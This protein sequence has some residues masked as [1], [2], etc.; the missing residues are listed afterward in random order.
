MQALG[1]LTQPKMKSPIKKRLLIITRNFPPLVGGM[2]RLNYHI[3]LELT[4][5]FD[6]AI[7][8]PKGCEKYLSPQTKFTLFP[9]KPLGLF[10]LK[11]FTSA[12]RLAIKEKPDLIIAGS[13]VTAII[14]LIAARSLGAKAMIFIHGLDILFPNP[15]YQLL[16]L[17]AIRSCD[18]IWV[19]SE[20]TSTLA[21]QKGIAPKKINILH[22]GVTLP[23]DNK[24]FSSQVKFKEKYGISANRKILLSVG[25]LTHRKGLAE[26][27]QYCL[28]KIV[29]KHPD[30]LLLIVGNNAKDALNK[31]AN[32]LEKIEQATHTANVK[33]HVLTLGQLSEDDLSQAYI[34]SE[35]LVFPVLNLPGDVEGFGMVAIEAAAHGLPTVAFAVGGVTDAVG[36]GISGW[37]VEQNN[38]EEFTQTVLNYLSNLHG[39]KSQIVTK[40]TCRQHATKFSWD[41]FGYQLTNTCKDILHS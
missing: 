18:G 37:L 28:A 32:I 30:I 27:I 41:R 5:E 25:R 20:H 16:F 2:E 9:H 22:P 36:H 21:K 40:Q 12:Y 13:G 29:Q 24:A 23:Q 8:G 34:C 26:F 33:D 1:Y 7:A 19:N 35:L 6:V 17:P 15:T 14:A 38:Y 4:K 3:Y 31:Q 11:S 10:L 39:P